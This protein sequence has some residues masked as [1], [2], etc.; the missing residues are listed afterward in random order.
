VDAR[1]R[2][3]ADVVGGVVVLDRSVEPLATVG[4]EDVS[5][6]H[7]NNRRDVRVPAVVPDVLLLGE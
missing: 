5:R 1:K 6:L 2:R 3:V 7:A 4:P